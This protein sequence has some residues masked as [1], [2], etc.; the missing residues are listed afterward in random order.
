MSFEVIPVR[1][2][3]ELKQFI[4]CPWRVYH[5][6]PYWVPPLLSEIK[7]T[8]DRQQNP[9][10]EHAEAEYFVAVRDG[11]A[12]GRVAAIINYSHIEFHQEPVGF[13]GFFETIPEYEIATALLDESANWLRDRGLQVMRGPMS[14]ST[15]DECAM[16]VEGF[17]AP[18]ALMMPYNPR[19]YPEYMER[20]GFQKAKDLLAYLFT[21]DQETPPKLVRVAETVRRRKHITVRPLNLKQLDKE[22]P[23]LEQIYNN[24]WEKNWGFVPVTS[25]EFQ[26]LAHQLKQIADKDLA[27]FAEIA[28]QPV[29]F[30]LALPDFNQA[31]KRANGR[32][33]PLGLLKLLLASRRIDGIRVLL[34]GVVDMYRQHGVEAL[35]LMEIF[36]AGRKKG[37]QWAEL[38]WILEDNVMMNRMSRN[39]GASAYKRYRIYDYAL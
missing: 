28:G 8:L 31:L 9:F 7:K 10:F 4:R 3:Q 15:N 6:D 32:L 39:F 27:L 22:I 24:A 16:L 25:K 23:L 29:G 12:V 33:F 19:Y 20:F 11:Q 18:P 35:L 14:F 37:Y 38:S 21:S 13:F 26:H 5:D 17:D 2:S 34:L 36:R 30:V 1:S